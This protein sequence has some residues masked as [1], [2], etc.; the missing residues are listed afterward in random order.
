MTTVET[1]LRSGSRPVR[2]RSKGAYP[3]VG[4]VLHADLLPPEA[5]WALTKAFRN[6]DEP[7]VG[8]TTDGTPRAGLYHAAEAL[9]GGVGAAARRAATGYLASLSAY[10]LAVGRLEVSSPDWRLWTNAFPTWAPKGLLLDALS[11]TSRDAALAVMRTSL[12]AS[13]FAT[14]R[15][16]M[17][18]NAA[19]GALVDDYTDSLREYMYWFT[20]YGHPQS[21]APWGWK[22]MGHHLDLH[23]VFVGDDL[24]FAPVFAGAE[25]TTALAGPYRGVSAFDRETDAGL[26]LRNT[27]QPGQEQRAVL[28]ASLRAADLPPELA[29]PFDGRHLAGAGSDNLVLP[30][31][32]LAASA[33]TPTQQQALVELIDV[34]LS[35]MPAAHAALKAQQ[36]RRHLDETHFAWRGGSGDTDA[37]YYRVHS[38]VLLVEYD[39]HPGIF[40]DND[41][42]ERFHVHTIVREPNGND[43]GRSLLAQ[44]YLT[45]HVRTP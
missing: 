19:L 25:P 11:E 28:S 40:L 18:L 36:V 24:V 23:C 45:H 8:I 20:V 33:M 22:L 16:A 38:P 1:G 9:E 35:R 42:P 34:Y 39:N 7:F 12:S 32:G 27:L 3:L 6:R 31:E 4:S 43:Y 5:A 44:H 30:H 21:D 29:G 14:V 41:E 17:Q 26:R 10:Q 2:A 15:A 13:G 37:F